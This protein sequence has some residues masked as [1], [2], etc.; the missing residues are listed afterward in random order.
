MSILGNFSTGFGLNNNL[1]PPYQLDSQGFPVTALLT[2]IN[3]GNTNQIC[4]NSDAL[5]TNNCA[6]G[7]NGRVEIV[8]LQ[9]SVTQRDIPAP[10]PL[11]G[12]VPLG[13]MLRKLSRKRREVLQTA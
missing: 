11:A 8:G 9:G 10:L 3:L 4:A 6:T 7:E 12:M 2:S 13:V 5:G 1:V